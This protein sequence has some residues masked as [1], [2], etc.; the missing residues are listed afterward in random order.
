MCNTQ[1]HQNR[2]RIICKPGPDLFMAVWLSRQNHKEIMKINISAI[3]MTTVIQYCMTAK[4]Y[5]RQQP[6]MTTYN[7]L[8][9]AS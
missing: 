6:K 4:K 8:E 7:S 9:Y 2:I 3:H 5:N 1:N